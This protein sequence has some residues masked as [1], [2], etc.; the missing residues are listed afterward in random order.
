[1][2]YLNITLILIF[3]LGGPLDL[4]HRCILCAATKKL[5]EQISP[6]LTHVAFP[7]D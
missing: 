1:M 5:A 7:D 6:L 3:R 4:L 2:N